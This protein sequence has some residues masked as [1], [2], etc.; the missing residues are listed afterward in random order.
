VQVSQ[1]ENLTSCIQEHIAQIVAEEPVVTALEC[2]DMH[3]QDISLLFMTI[4]A[5]YVL[6]EPFL[7]QEHGL[8]HLAHLEHIPKLTDQQLARLVPKDCSTQTTAQQ[9]ASVVDMGSKI[10]N[11]EQHLLNFHLVFVLLVNQEGTLIP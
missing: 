7:Y 10:S 8:A 9:P 6:L 1:K 11:P 3:N 5:E 4:S 2:A